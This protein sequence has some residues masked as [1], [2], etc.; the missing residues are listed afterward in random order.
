MYL[1]LDNLNKR[2]CSIHGWKKLTP[3]EYRILSCLSAKPGEM[4][5]SR[6][7]YQYIWQEEPCDCEDVICVHIHNLRRKIEPDPSSPSFLLV[8]KGKG[9][10]LS[11]SCLHQQLSFTT[12]AS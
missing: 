3:S 1:I 11:P 10:Y 5:T 4:F 2:V 9:Y 6:Q 8:R 7:L 12:S